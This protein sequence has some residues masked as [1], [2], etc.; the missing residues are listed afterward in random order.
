M[1]KKWSSTVSNL[2]QTKRE[3]SKRARQF[4]DRSARELA[5]TYGTDEADEESAAQDECARATEKDN[6][7]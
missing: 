6:G 7:F 5:Q 1:T 4:E 2:T 3:A